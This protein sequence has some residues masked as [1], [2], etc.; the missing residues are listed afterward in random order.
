MSVAAF[1]INVLKTQ[2]K[3]DDVMNC[4][5]EPIKMLDAYK[6]FWKNYVKF[7][8]RSRRSEFWWVILVNM[9]IGIVFGIL[10]LIPFIGVVFDVLYVIFVIACIIP[11][12]SLY[13]RRLHDIGKSGAFILLV[14]IPIVGAIILI[15]WFAKDSEPG[16]NRFGDNPKEVY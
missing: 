3:R 2:K 15:I 6:L 4:S 16:P 9:I 14:L 12:F 10:A 7:E 5:S 11:Y 1:L 8:G 13:F